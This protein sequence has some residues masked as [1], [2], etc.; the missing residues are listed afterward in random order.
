MV[1]T[2]FSGNVAGSMHHMP[3]VSSSRGSADPFY[4]FS[5]HLDNVRSSEASDAS[6]FHRV[7]PGSF[8]H[9]IAVE[10][11]ENNLMS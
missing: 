10:R 7:P 4:K 3:S 6:H 2:T 1:K 11:V 8:S 9:D 5:S